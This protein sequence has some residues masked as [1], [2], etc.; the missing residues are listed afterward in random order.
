MDNLKY[1]KISPSQPLNVLVFGAGAI[2]VYVGG[3]LALKGHNVVFLE[4]PQVAADLLEH[5]LHLEVFGIK[6]QIPSPVVAASIEECLANGPFDVGVF[7]LKSFDTQTALESLVPFSGSLPPILC[8]QNGVDNEPAIAA[9]LGAD[10]VIAGTVTSAIGKRGV[11]DIVVE[12]LRGIGVSAAHP[13]STR[14]VEALMDA[15]LNAQLYQNPD[16][17]K[18]S[19]MITNLVG[20]ASAAILDMPP[21]EIF[22]HPELYRLEIHQL[23][24]ALSVMEALSI[25]VVDLPSTPVRLLAFGSQKLPLWLSRPLLGRAVGGG[26]GAKMPSFHIDLHSGRGKSEVEYLNGAVARHGELLGVPTPTNRLLTDA[27]ISL[28]NGEIPLESYAHQP[29]KLLSKWHHEIKN[30]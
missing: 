15:G 24:E 2:G 6:K 9:A 23:R 4:R 18:W 25:P 30:K 17:M 20:N 27:L 22:A 11:G 13:L 28:T 3:S 14:L 26:R 12:R 16:S 29:E 19:K 1:K 8:L 5:G 21:A 10:K 7:A